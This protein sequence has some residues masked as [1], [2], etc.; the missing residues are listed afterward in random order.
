M[1]GFTA[2]TDEQETRYQRACDLLG[3]LISIRSAWIYDEEKKPVPSQEL[4]NKWEEEQNEYSS[5]RG[6]LDVFDD[7]QVNAVFAQYSAQHQSD[8]AIFQTQLKARRGS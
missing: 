5:I 7:V 6:R 1:T 4:L 3:N 8:N 2:P